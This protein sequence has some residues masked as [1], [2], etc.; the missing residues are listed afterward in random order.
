MEKFELE[1]SLILILQVEAM[2]EI[3]IDDYI[4]RVNRRMTT[5]LQYSITASDEER[6]L[7]VKLDN[8][9]VLDVFLQKEG[10]SDILYSY[11]IPGKNIKL[12]YT[13]FM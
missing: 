11:V 1:L 7:V 6:H 9:I 3:S 8:L 4:N 12:L 13:E 2:E 5:P 10:L